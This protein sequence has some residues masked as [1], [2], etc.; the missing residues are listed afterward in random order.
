MLREAAQ[1]LSID[2]ERSWCVG[3]SRRDLAAGAALGVRGILVATGKGRE[4]AAAARREGRPVD[5]FAPD[6]RAAVDHIL[7]G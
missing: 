3:D 6:L 4:E 7:A 1:E 2:L 5:L